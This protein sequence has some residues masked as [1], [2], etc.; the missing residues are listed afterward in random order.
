MKIPK[1]T[2]QNDQV[3]KNFLSLVS[4][5]TT[6]KISIDTKEDSHGEIKKVIKMLQNLVGD[7]QEIFTNQPVSESDN[8]P[9]SSPFANI[10]GDASAQPSAPTSETNQTATQETTTET[11]E[12]TEDLF[13]EL[14]SEEE[15]K[16]MDSVKSKEEEEDEEEGIKQK[17]KDKKYG[18]EFY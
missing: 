13:A 18:I 12:S 6:M 3:T 11:P 16:K 14:F 4:N 2:C 5:A 10:F 9:A 15:L 8:E 1:K 17:S 7:S